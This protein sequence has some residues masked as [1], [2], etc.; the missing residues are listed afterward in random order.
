MVMRT[1]VGVSNE[2]FLGKLVRLP[3]RLIPRGWVVTVKGGIN[4]GA[5]WI[6]GASTHG[7]WLGSYEADTQELVARLVRPGM[8]V[9]DLG[10]NAGFYTLAFARLA[11]VSG[12]VYAFEPLAENVANL[13]A[14]IRLNEV[15]N[16]TV[17]QAALG[18]TSGLSAFRT[19]ESNS[20]GRVSR[21]ETGYL[22]PSISMDDFLES[23]PGARPDLIKIDVE[24][25]ESEVLA[26]GQRFLQQAAPEIVLATHGEQQGK[27]CAEILTSFGYSLFRLDGAAVTAAA[28]RTDEIHAR[29]VVGRQS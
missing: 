28:S 23:H 25:A 24:G 20:M 12:R 7:C 18:R 10:A 8:T 29:K 13:L 4:K 5:S 19:A 26:G 1:P 17:I 21:E 9:W 15:G 3:L 6:V 27:A 11:G 16:A 22:V 2:S 14:H